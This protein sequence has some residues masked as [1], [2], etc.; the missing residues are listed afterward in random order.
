MMDIINIFKVIVKDI[1]MIS[2]DA[3]V[4]FN[5]IKIGEIPLCLSCN[6]IE[7]L[8]CGDCYLFDCYRE[9]VEHSRNII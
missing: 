4:A 7:N 3:L 2:L 6:N 1:F 5:L 8:I 9:C